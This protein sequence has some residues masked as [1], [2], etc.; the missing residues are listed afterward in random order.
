[1]RCDAALPPEVYYAT[2]STDSPERPDYDDGTM[3][4]RPFSP[5]ANRCPSD[6]PES[7]GEY[8][9]DSSAVGDADGRRAERW[10][11]RMTRG[12]PRVRLDCRVVSASVGRSVAGLRAAVRLNTS[13]PKLLAGARPRT[14]AV[15]DIASAYEVTVC[16]DWVALPLAILS[17]RAK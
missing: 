2:T 5:L 16:R 11:F 15:R 12:G 9:R 7:D 6:D 10:H 14:R 4:E 8:Q 13:V 1:M 17:A 3:A